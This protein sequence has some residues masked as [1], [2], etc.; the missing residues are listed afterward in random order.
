MKRRTF[1]STIGAGSIGTGALVGTGGFSRVESQRR[2][3]IEVGPDDDEDETRTGISFV[4][5]C[6]EANDA[7]VPTADHITITV[8][9]TKEDDSELEAVGIDWSS[10]VPIDRVVLKGGQEWYVFEYDGAEENEAEMEGVEEGKADESM[11]PQNP[12]G[13]GFVGV[14]FEWDEDTEE[15]VPEDD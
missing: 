12:C 4:A 13:D 9:Q 15:F 11:E 3:K 10:D 8:T 7:D 5:F 2:V 1:L 14:K 6:V